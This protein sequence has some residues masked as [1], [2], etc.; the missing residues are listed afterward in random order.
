APG[1]A[2]RDLAAAMTSGLL[3]ALAAAFAASVEPLPVPRA[4]RGAIALV[5]R[6]EQYLRTRPM[7]PAF[8]AE[9]SAVLGVAP[10]TLHKAFVAACGMSPQAYLKRRRLMQVH[11]ALKAGGPDTL[12]VKSAALSHGFWHL[13]N[14]AAAYREQFGQMPSETMAQARAERRSG[15]AGFAM[16]PLPTP[17]PIA[18]AAGQ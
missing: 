13:G 8:T 12:L 2:T 15:V 3:D 6:A 17:A 16:A 5:D 14:F 7:A 1:E 11:A 18:V 10:R 4:T 9:L